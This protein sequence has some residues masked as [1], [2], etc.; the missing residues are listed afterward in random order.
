MK[1]IRKQ[2]IKEENSL[3]LSGVIWATINLVNK[4]I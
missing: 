3:Y 1:K 2:Q 4:I